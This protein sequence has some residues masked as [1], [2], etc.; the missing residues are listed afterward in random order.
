MALD[1][2]VN[3]TNAPAPGEQTLV[4]TADPFPAAALPRTDRLLVVSARLH[5]Q[6]LER[7]LRESG[8]DPASATLLSVWPVELDYDGPVSLS[9]VVHPG[10]VTGV[11]MRLVDALSTLSEGDCVVTDALGVLEM[12]CEP[13][14]V[15]RFFSAVLQK[16]AGRRL[17]GVHAV[18]PGV[19]VDGALKA[20]FDRVVDEPARSF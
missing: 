10:D 20:Q 3:A 2:D 18:Q 13:D 9:G 5:P 12:Y 11:G 16:T 4:R 7:L 1:V 14:I 8:F 17:H 15:S 6:R 19:A